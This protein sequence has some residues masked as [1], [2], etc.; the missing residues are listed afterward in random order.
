MMEATTD[1]TNDRCAMMDTHLTWHFVCLCFSFPTHSPNQYF[2]S[3]IVEH[4]PTILKN[5]PKI[6]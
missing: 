1:A 4:F 2:S 5:W 3:E 6:G